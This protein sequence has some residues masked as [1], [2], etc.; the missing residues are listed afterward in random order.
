MFVIFLQAA[1]AYTEN[2]YETSQKL[3]EEVFHIYPWIFL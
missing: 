3:L 2:D 1:D